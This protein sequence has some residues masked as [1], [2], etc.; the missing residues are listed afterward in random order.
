MQY[1][2]RYYS[3]LEV[4]SE[5]FRSGADKISIG[6]DAVYAA[7]EYLKTGVGNY[8]LFN[9]FKI[10]SFFL[11]CYTKILLTILLLCVRK[12]LLLIACNT[13]LFFTS[14]YCIYNWLFTYNSKVLKACYIQC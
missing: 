5:Y 14:P 10:Y 7:E 11:F 12:M 1:I 13:L 9:K 8:F 2:Y 6:S 4:A 3:S